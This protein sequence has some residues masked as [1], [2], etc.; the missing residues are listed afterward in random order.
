MRTKCHGV[1]RAQCPGFVAGPQVRLA[2]ICSLSRNIFGGAAGYDLYT[3]ELRSGHEA[4]TAP[5]TQLGES[6]SSTS[7]PFVV[8]TSP[9]DPDTF[10]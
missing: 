1:A 6:R 10:S 7:I 2:L 3:T 9:R 4:G 8:M 5:L